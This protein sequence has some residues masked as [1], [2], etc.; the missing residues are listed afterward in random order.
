[1]SDQTR[2]QLVATIH[3]AANRLHQNDGKGDDKKALNEAAKL[4][5]AVTM[6]E[7]LMVE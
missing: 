2:A 3:E 1:M 7:Q 5:T 4:L 6:Y